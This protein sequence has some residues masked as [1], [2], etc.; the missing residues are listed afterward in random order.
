MADLVQISTYLRAS[1]NTPLMQA[2]PCYIFIAS[3]VE[4]IV[5]Q[6]VKELGYNSVIEVPVEE[7][8]F[9]ILLAKKE[10]YWRFATAIAPSYDLETE[11]TKLVKSKRFD[12]YFKLLSAIISE[13]DKSPSSIK[14]ADVTLRSREGSARN[15]VLSQSIETGA[16]L[17]NITQ[18]SVCIDW[19][20]FNSSKGTLVYYDI[21]LGTEEMYD[22]YSD[23]VVDYSKAQKRINIIDAKRTKY[24]ITD[25]T[26]NTKYYIVIVYKALSGIYFAQSSFTTLE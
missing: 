25:L 8:N 12:H 16:T 11:F 22:E 13:I 10:L 3:D 6:V 21:L 5:N 24:R 1:I 26:P 17:S 7:E 14:V 9:L 18:T 19:I 23:L 4:N 2:D 15:Y 20:G